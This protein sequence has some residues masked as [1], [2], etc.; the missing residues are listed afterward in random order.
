MFE[1]S[2]DPA[3]FCNRP[4]F[5]L[6]RRPSDRRIRPR[7]GQSRIFRLPVPASVAAL[8]A[9][10]CTLLAYAATRHSP[11]LDEPG[12]LVGGLSHWR[13]GRFEVFR[14]NPPLVRMVAA[15]PVMAVGYEADWSKFYD[16]PGARP[17]FSMDDSF[18]AANGARSMWLFTVARWGCIPFSVAGALFCFSWSRELW[19]SDSAGLIALTLWCFEPTILAHAELITTD[20][21]ATSLGLGAAY[22]F[23][24]WSVRLT[25]GSALAAGVLLGLAELTKTTWILLFILWPLLYLCRTFLFRLYH[26]SAQ[27]LPALRPPAASTAQLAAILTLAL[28]IINL[29]YSFDG[30]LTSLGRYTFVSQALTGGTV[31]GTPGN[32]FSDDLLAALPVPLPRHYVLGIDTQKLD[33]ENYGERSYLRGVWRDGGWWYYYLYGLAVKT[34]HGLHVLLLLA[35]VMAGVR[36]IPGLRRSLSLAR[37]KVDLYDVAALLAPPISLI[38]LV[39]SQMEFN[40]HVRYVLPALG[41]LIVAAGAAA[42]WLPPGDDLLAPRLSD[43]GAAG[44]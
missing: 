27:N 38:A 11:T 17:E 18:I 36:C 41:F 39:S 23:W 12:H 28:Y 33:L 22:T 1:H 6:A 40:H 42:L 29:G 35:V 32:R 14:V 30:T 24:R 44:R 25:W 31:P 20:C 2:A 8:L 4:R 3:A 34:S 7:L 9:V 26:P 10:H 15:L 13:F 21:A 19:S 16:S 5:L 37:T 43:S